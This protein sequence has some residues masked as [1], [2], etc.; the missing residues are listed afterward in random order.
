MK[1]AEEVLSSPELKEPRSI[2]LDSEVSVKSVS[3]LSPEA[4]NPVK[5]ARKKSPATGASGEA[6]ELRERV[7]LLES[8]LRQARLE[9]ENPPMQAPGH[10]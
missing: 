3:E 2:S 5:R 1:M 9:R 10:L 6:A 7:K 8:E 4:K